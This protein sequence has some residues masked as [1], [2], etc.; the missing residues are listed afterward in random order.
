MHLDRNAEATEALERCVALRKTIFGR[1]YLGF[2]ISS[3]SSVAFVDDHLLAVMRPPLDAGIRWTNLLDL[4][5]L[6][7]TDGESRHSDRDNSRG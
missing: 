1:L 3:V 6:T 2:R 5:H 4:L 7:V